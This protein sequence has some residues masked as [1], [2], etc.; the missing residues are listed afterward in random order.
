MAFRV[1]FPEKCRQGSDIHRVVDCDLDG[2]GVSPVQ[3]EEVRRLV[4]MEDHHVVVVV[5]DSHVVECG[6]AALFGEIEFIWF[7]D[8]DLAVVLPVDI[9]RE[10]CGRVDEEFVP[11]PESEAPCEPVADGGLPLGEEM[12]LLGEV[13]LDLGDVV[14]AFGADS[15]YELRVDSPLQLD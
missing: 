6:D 9:L 10:P 13:L 1:L 5:A 14:L 3:P 2:G 11:Q 4:D 7:A 12:P 8:V 15:A